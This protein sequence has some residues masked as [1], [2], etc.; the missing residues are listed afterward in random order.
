MNRLGPRFV[1]SIRAPTRRARWSLV[2]TLSALLSA[3][4]APTGAD[5]PDG[6]ASA[7]PL[8]E[9]GSGQLE[10]ESLESQDPTLELVFGAQGGFHVWGRARTRSF[11]P[12]LE[13]SFRA[14]RESDGLELHRP[15]PV[16]RWI[17]DGVRYGL[18]PM[19]DGR[20]Q[21]DAELVILSLDCARNL[22]GQR[23]TLELTVR[24][25][26]TGRSASTR[27]SLR[28]VDEI[29]SPST[30]VSLPDGSSAAPMDAAADR[31]ADGS[32]SE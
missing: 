18:Y 28:V 6:D 26:R 21:T 19:P 1:S 11:E 24:E 7:E 10:W 14:V 2:A 16:R 25:R 8:V 23:L 22:V 9:L 30:C 29:P 17:A 31:G 13:V 20:F 12:D 32:P 4:P 27:R 3:C 15:S 5:V